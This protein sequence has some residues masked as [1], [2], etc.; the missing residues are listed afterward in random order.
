MLAHDASQALASTFRSEPSKRDACGRWQ[1][2]GEKTAPAVG[3]RCADLPPIPETPR[4]QNKGVGI[5]EGDRL[6]ER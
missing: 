1:G 5:E 3:E 4:T 6:K 2:D